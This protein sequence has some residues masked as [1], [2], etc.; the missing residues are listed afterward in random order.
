[1]DLNGKVAVITGSSS[2]IGKAT[3]LAFARQ[4]A[5]VVVNSRSNS[6]GGEA[7]AAEIRA[8]GGQALHVQA[9]LTD[10]GQVAGLFEKTLDAF[11]TIDILVNNAGRTRAVP[12]LEAD[13][14]HWQQAFDENLFSTVLCAHAAAKI[15]LARGRGRIINTSSIRG[16]QYAGTKVAI[17]YSA[18][19]AAVV[20]FSKTL[21]KELAPHITVN[22]VA[23]GFTYTENYDR[24]AAEVKENMLANMPLKHFVT[25]DDVA[26][27]SVFLAAADSITGQVLLVDGGFT[28]KSA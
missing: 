27:A 23:P 11:G 8:S 26:Q 14:A 25:V 18:A 3:A 28:L 17:A 6:A 20:S 2:G 15:M 16:V 5:V 13:K 4:G 22:V 7:V 12:F 21:A 24:M 9:N 1:M 19:K 10:E